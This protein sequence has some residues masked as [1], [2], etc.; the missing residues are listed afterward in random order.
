MSET[1][2]VPSVAEGLRSIKDIV[3]DLR[4]PIAQKHLKSR[5]QA[6]VTLTYIPWYHATRYLDYY[7]NCNWNY[8]VVSIHNDEKYCIVKTR[9]TITCLEGEVSREA[10]GVE[11]LASK[12]YGDYLS[13]ACS[14]ALRRTAAMFGLGI[15]LYDKG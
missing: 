13:N 6:G 1:K 15:A 11:E 10:T 4:K 2:E 3:E 8:E 7:T 9:I 14:M 5:K 12:G